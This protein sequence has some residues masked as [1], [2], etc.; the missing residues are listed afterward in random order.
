M[1][2]LWS[3]FRFR[4]FCAVL[5]VALASGVIGLFSVRAFM[6]DR[7]LEDF[8]EMLLRHTRLSAGLVQEASDPAQG[9]KL[10]E[11]SFGSW[12]VRCSITD[13]RGRVLLES[14][15]GV[16]P[17][18]MDNHGDRPEMREA[19]ASGAGF[20]I[21][22]SATLGQDYAYAASVLADGRILRLALPLPVLEDVIADRMAVLSQ[23][24][25]V[26][27]VV[28]IL[29]AVLLSGA[30]KASLRSM[31]DMVE[32]LSRGNFRR[33]LCRLPG[34]EFA[35]L[36]EAVNHMAANIEREVRH[37]ADQAAQLEAVLDTMSD[38]VLV[39]GPQ[40]QIRRC[41]AALVRLFPVVGRQLGAQVIEAIPHPA[42]QE[43]VDSL[44]AERMDD[45]SDSAQ[46]QL[47]LE[48]STGISLAVVL[49]RSGLAEDRLGLVAVFRDVSA[50]VRLER[51]RRD[52]VANVSHE[53][54]T[55]LTAIQGSA[56]TLLELEGEPRERR[57]AEII[58]RHA[59]SLSRM[60]DDLLQLAR[61][62]ARP[63]GNL[64]VV[65]VCP[66]LEQVRGLCRGPLEA[67]RLELE[68]HVPGDCAVRAHGRLLMQVFRNLVE[69]A[70]RYAPEGGAIRLFALPEGDMWRFRVVDDGPGIP[71]V[72][73]SRIFERFYQV[74]RHR[75]Q[76]GTGL[77]LAICKHA[78]EQ[79]GGRIGVRSP[80]PDGSTAFEFTLGRAE[81]HSPVKEENA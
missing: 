36:V 68:S 15:G 28:A 43:A 60:V 45:T 25:A 80:A 21:R 59:C 46:R 34:Q 54:R 35:P 18:S 6:Y 33:R 81:A 27:A 71:E 56:E 38:G 26:A 50:F 30:L 5:V 20:A 57:F 42:L 2:Q 52:F 8:R 49:S 79:C 24:A 51:V 4:I 40:G 53:L 22:H 44:L 41:N 55:P 29:L 31:I 11:Q 73:Q 37:S 77:G 1:K 3:S 75:S 7:Q 39:L 48:L 12:P 16:A 13:A 62:D 47:T 70:C 23:V 78:V 63:V 17:E 74:E 64:E 19:A 67:R 66:V 58:Y 14:A 65:E 72:E 9:M 32:A 76:G 69:N 61:L 10:V